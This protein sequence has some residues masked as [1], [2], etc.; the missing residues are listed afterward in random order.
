MTEQSAM[1]DM[2]DATIVHALKGYVVER[3]LH[4]ESI[5]LDGQTPLLEW[6]LIDSLAMAD[7]L[8]FIEERFEITLPDEE[9]RPEHFESLNSLGQ[10]IVRRRD[11]GRAG[12]EGSSA[13]APRP[14]DPYGLL[15][16]SH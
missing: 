16:S 2:P 10:L 13:A 14:M 7:L 5:D 3:I 12:R 8:A 15:K 1:D 11:V 6:G 4:G 9:V